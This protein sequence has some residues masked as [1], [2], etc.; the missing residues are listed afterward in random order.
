MAEKS[1]SRKTKKDDPIETRTDPDNLPTWPE[2]TLLIEKT[3]S[4]AVSSAVSTAVTKAV[5]EVMANI[6]SEL[7]CVNTHLSTL[8]GKFMS[9]TNEL[10]STTTNHSNRLTKLEEE[11]ILIQQ[12][13]EGVNNSEESIHKLQIENKL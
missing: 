13:D 10:A 5:S 7:A 4:Q 1:A 12:I 8:E 11:V 9:F 2:L 6:H 3:V